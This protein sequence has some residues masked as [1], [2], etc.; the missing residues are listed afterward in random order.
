MIRIDKDWYRPIQVD[1]DRYIKY[2]THLCFNVPQSFT[3]A[4]LKNPNS[5]RWRS[6]RAFTFHDFVRVE[7][8]QVESFAETNVLSNV[9]GPLPQEQKEEEVLESMNLNV[10]ALS[11]IPME[12]LISCKYPLL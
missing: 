6:L 10:N 2:G 8:E 3:Y 5:I 4:A 1:I 11:N 7:A 9:A 12:S